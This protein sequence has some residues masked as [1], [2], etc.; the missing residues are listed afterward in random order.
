[1]MRKAVLAVALFAT[2]TGMMVKPAVAA[3]APKIVLAPPGIP[4]IFIS[5]VVFVAKDQGFFKKYGAD[6]ELRQFDNGTAAAR[7]VVAG[8]LD[9]S[10]SAT[11]LL[12]TQIANADV[13]LVGIYGF[14]KPDFQLGT[15]NTA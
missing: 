15:T 2:L 1:M 10:M 8:D 5:I 13:D 12:V 3:D 9:A 7:A 6:V 4:P 11:P 14:P